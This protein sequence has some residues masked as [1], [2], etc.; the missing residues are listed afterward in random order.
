M[1][2]ED[3]GGQAFGA[4]DRKLDSDL[5]GAVFAPVFDNLGGV[6]DESDKLEFRAAAADCAD[7]G[8][9]VELNRRE[10]A[11]EVVISASPCG[12]ACELCGL[13]SW[14]GGIDSNQLDLSFRWHSRFG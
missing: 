12:L 14:H 13:V 5:A 3:K 8:A 2:F 7:G 10:N 4:S 1:N 9:G 6:L 11:L